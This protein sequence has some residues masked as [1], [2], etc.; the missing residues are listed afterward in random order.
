MLNTQIDV[1]V[2][3]RNIP[4]DDPTREPMDVYRLA[5]RLGAMACL[6][7][8]YQDASPEERTERAAEHR[9]VVEKYPE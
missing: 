8:W 5:C 7:L 4:C 6:P 2:S 1:C 3:E 9:A